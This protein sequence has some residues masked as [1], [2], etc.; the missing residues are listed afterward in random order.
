MDSA[1]S[2]ALA[3]KDCDEVIAISFMYGS[4]HEAAECE[5]AALVANYYHVLREV[6]RLPYCLFKGAGSVLLSEGEMPHATYSELQAS[7]GP[8]PT[9]VPFRNPVMISMAVARAIVYEADY[10]YVAMHSEDAHHFAYPDC[11][12]ECVGPLGAAIY[13]GSYHKVRLVVPFQWM[14]KADIVYSALRLKV[15]LGLTWSCYDPVIA[16]ETQGGGYVAC[17]LCPTCKERIQAFRV[18]WL[19]DPIAYNVPIK[20]PDNFNHYPSFEVPR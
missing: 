16:P 2:L 4:K 15:P 8:S 18:N 1:T 5:A 19:I 12:P 3:K 6:T 14:S 9:V 20:W 7:E 10:V 17:G 13:V 11:T